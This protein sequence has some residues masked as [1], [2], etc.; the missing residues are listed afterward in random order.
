[1]ADAFDGS[2]FSHQ[3]NVADIDFGDTHKYSVSSSEDISWLYLDDFTGQLN[4]TPED[5]HVGFYNLTF[6][7]EDAEGASSS[8]VVGLTVNNVNDPV[9]VDADQSILFRSD[10]QN[11]YFISVSDEDLNDSY[12]FSSDNL[13]SWMSLDASTGELFGKPTRDDDGIYEINISVEDAGGLTDTQTVEVISTSFEYSILGSGDDI[14]IGDGDR[15]YISTGGGNDKVIS[16]AGDDVVIVQGEGEVEVDTGIGDDRVVVEEGFSGT[17]FVKNGAGSNILEFEGPQQHDSAEFVDGKLEI[18]SSNGAT[19]VVDNQWSLNTETGLV[20][21]SDTG[22]QYIK[23]EGL[24]EGGDDGRSTFSIIGS[25]EAN[26]LLASQP[27][28]ASGN[29]EVYVWSG[30]G[31]DIIEGEAN[32]LMIEGGRGDDLIRIA[33][34]SGSKSVFGD[35]FHGDSGGNIQ[36]E[37]SSYADVVEIDWSYAASEISQHGS[38]YQIYNEALDATL[39]VYDVEILKFANDDGS[40]DTRYLTD[41]APIGQDDWMYGHAGKQV[42]Y[43]DGSGVRFVLTNKPGIVPM[44]YDDGS[45]DGASVEQASWLQVYGHVEEMVSETYMRPEAYTYYQHKSTG[46]I[47]STPKRNY[48]QKT[49]TR[50]VEDVREVAHVSEQLIWEGD[51]TS[52]DAFNFSDGISIN[53]INVADKDWSDQPIEQTI[54]T[55]GIDLIFGND[56][57]NLIDAGLGDD[58]IFGGDGDDVIIGGEGDDI[59]LGGEGNDVIRGDTVMDDDAALAYFAALTNYDDSQLSIDNSG[60]GTGGNDVLIGGDGIDDIASGEGENF[61]A[62]GNADLDGDGKMDAELVKEFMDE[63]DINNKDIFNDDETV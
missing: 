27:S 22:F 59:I 61:V 62:S 36:S 4:G 7:V 11:S 44:S 20:E 41:G 40:W 57:D 49:G 53:V 48:L 32:N 43:G 14:V 21:I 5:E 25:N 35:F 24:F 12:T 37:N 60:M 52:V 45:D 39:N 28:E 2:V 55:D 18:Y 16:G 6:S 38:G 33:A 31:A 23:T 58:I 13:A 3:L 51:K 42:D 34:T 17:L 54:G 1:M 63:H 9:F 8:E 47:R 46:Q 15:D 26:Y 56:S 19:V 29:D 30:D 10:I 50:E